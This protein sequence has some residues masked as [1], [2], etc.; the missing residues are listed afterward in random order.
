MSVHKWQKLRSKW[1]THTLPPPR[2]AKPGTEMAVRRRLEER[3]LSGQLLGKATV[4]G[5]LTSLPGEAVPTDRKH[6]HSA[7][8]TRSNCNCG[9]LYWIRTS[10][11]S[12]TRSSPLLVWEIFCAFCFCKIQRSE[13]RSPN[14]DIK[15]LTNCGWDLGPDLNKLGQ[16]KNIGILFPIKCLGAIH[17]S[18]TCDTMRDI[19]VAK[20]LCHPWTLAVHFKCLLGPL[21]GGQGLLGQSPL[22]IKLL[23]LR[24][25]HWAKRDKGGKPGCSPCS[26]T[27]VLYN[28]EQ[29]SSLLR[30]SVF[31]S[32]NFFSF[33]EED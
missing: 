18:L 33:F 29:V 17:S 25:Q 21:S 9:H 13:G 24:D 11:P 1:N 27:N 23:G 16:I 26:I 2:M 10:C 20:S 5:Q 30:T 14:N 8:S 15:F 3:P 12:S 4:S 7:R 6:Q 19:H 22:W 32:V 31:W 28:F